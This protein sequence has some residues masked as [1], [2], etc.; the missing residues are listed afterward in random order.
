MESDLSSLDENQD[1]LQEE[2]ARVIRRARVFRIRKDPFNTFD[3]ND[4]KQRYRLSKATV[5]DLVHNIGN[6]LK[7]K[8]CRNKS[9]SPLEQILLTLR[10]YAT[11]AFQQLVGDDLRIHKSTACRVIQRV[12]HQ[13]AS[14][15]RQH[16]MMPHSADDLAATKTGFYNIANFPRVVGAIDCTHIKI[17]SPGGERAELYRNRKG[18]FSL[19][20][21]CICDADLKLRHI[22]ARW[23]GS[24]HDS[25]IFNH[26]PLPAEFEMGTYGNGF[27]LGDSGYACKPYLLTPLL[28]PE[29]RAEVNYN[30][31]QIRT[32]NTVERFFGVLKR[33]FPCLQNGL[34]LKLE[35]IPKVIVACGVLH[36]ICKQQNDEFVDENVDQD[37]DD[38]PDL[39][40]NEIEY[41]QEDQNN[42]NYL[43]R[44]TVIATVFAG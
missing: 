23:P 2:A 27:L 5:M 40:E 6:D 42:P 20:V 33:R 8:T 7:H 44:N 4:F 36:N 41:V 38:V 12:T 25:T 30:R 24:V 1:I 39:P 17:Q 29:T 14:L 21:Q 43:V 16:I 37:M 32:R 34:R 31:A 28:T 3:D 13:I 22:V 11:G 10:F 15:S 9:L 26:S 19:N 18:Y 35:T